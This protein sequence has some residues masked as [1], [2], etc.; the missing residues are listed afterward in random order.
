MCYLSAQSSEGSTHDFNQVSYAEL[1]DDWFGDYESFDGLNRYYSLC[2]GPGV[3][4]SSDRFVYE[5]GS[6]CFDEDV[7]F[8][9]LWGKDRR[10]RQLLDMGS[11]GHQ[12]DY[13]PLLTAGGSDRVDGCFL[14][15][16]RHDLSLV[17]L[18]CCRSTLSRGKCV[19]PHKPE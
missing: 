7:S 15:L 9:D 6:V 16:L 12:V 17:D 2:S 1:F 3:S 11:T 14:G 5:V 8:D 4:R 19:E 18:S 13:G 10:Y